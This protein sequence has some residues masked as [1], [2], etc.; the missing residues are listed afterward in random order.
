MAQ[1]KINQAG[2]DL[3]KQ[4]EGC[5]LTAYLCPAGYWTI[6]YGHAIGV[7]PGQTVT[8]EQADDLLQKDMATFCGH[9]QKAFPKLNDNQFS[10]LV[11]LCF[12][13][14]LGPLMM[15]LGKY[16]TMG[17]LDAAADQFLRWNKVKGEVSKGLSRRR[18]AERALFLKEVV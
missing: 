1:R 10:A 14:G 5:S 15:T 7:K 6:G 4:F 2:I 18:D 3:I 16:I 12:N 17:N 13:V 9:V 11:S 8:Q